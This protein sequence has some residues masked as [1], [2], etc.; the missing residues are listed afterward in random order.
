MLVPHVS[1]RHG[2]QAR[3]L[4][5]CLDLPG[6]WNKKLGVLESPGSLFTCVAPLTIIPFTAEGGRR[7][8]KPTFLGLT[9]VA[10][11]HYFRQENDSEAVYVGRVSW[12]SN[13]ARSCSQTSDT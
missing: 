13:R 11:S 6:L 12:S 8:R 10:R 9:F 7:Q 1:T 2:A 4:G 5:G 3:C